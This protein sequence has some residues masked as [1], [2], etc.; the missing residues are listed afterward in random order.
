MGC[1]ELDLGP[2]SWK[3]TDQ[4]NKNIK[5]QAEIPDAALV[6][7]HHFSLASPGY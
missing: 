2:S 3:I 7:W 1:S 5:L 6:D 4:L